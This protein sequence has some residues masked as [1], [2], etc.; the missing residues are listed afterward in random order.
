MGINEHRQTQKLCHYLRHMKLRMLDLLACPYDKH[1]PLKLHIFE[2]GVNEKI[3]VPLPNKNSGVV[4][5][6]YCEFKGFFLVEIADDGTE[7]HKSMELIREHVTPEDCEACHRREI[8]NGI[9]KCPTCSR[10]FPLIDEIPELLP[11]DIRC[12]ELSRENAWIKTHAEE[13]EKAGLTQLVAE[14]MG[15]IAVEL[16]KKEKRTKKTKKTKK[17]D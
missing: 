7:M 11:D 14:N 10:H 4:C 15:R 2:E 13:I 1:W 3:H 12:R 9:F 16:E 6:F 5:E 17:S 8:I